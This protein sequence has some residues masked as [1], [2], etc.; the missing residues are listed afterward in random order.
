[1]NSKT[2][3][4]L[5]FLLT[6]V[7]IASMVTNS[8]AQ[9]AQPA[10]IQ[11]AEGLVNA[12]FGAQQAGTRYSCVLT[13]G[14]NGFMLVC[15]P[16]NPT[17]TPVVQPTQTQSPPTVIPSVT[18]TA[19]SHETNT[20]MPTQPSPT[21]NSGGSILPFAGSPLCPDTNGDGHSDVTDNVKYGTA[22]DSALWH[23]L[24]NEVDGCHYDHEHGD[25]P[26]L[27]D[28]IFGALG[29]QWGGSGIDHPFHT[30]DE[31]NNF[32]HRAHK[33][34]VFLNNACV[35]INGAQNCI[36]NFRILHHLDFHAMGTRF[37]SFWIEM[38]ICKPSN[39][40]DCGIVRRGGHLDFGP[41]VNQSQPGNVNGE[42]QVPIPADL[43]PFPLVTCGTS[44]R[45]A[46]NPPNINNSRFATWYGNQYPSFGCLPSQF[47]ADGIALG[48]I[49]IGVLTADVWAPLDLANPTEPNVTCPDGSCGQ[50]N[51][52]REQ[53][54]LV[55]GE[56]NAQLDARDGVTDGYITLKGFANIY[57]FID[58]SCTAVSV[59]CVPFE[60]I[61][62][63]V[64]SYQFRFNTPKEYDIFFN[65]QTSGWIVYPN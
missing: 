11:N 8:T 42:L 43:T 36:K 20:P 25:N 26:A 6:I 18:Q 9:I 5:L 49:Q 1:M 56:F 10:I 52:R 57:G 30:P 60:F 65:G 55:A 58:S 24:W 46:H 21:P 54:H 33:V 45:R 22:P 50:N 28:A 48:V 53:G 47:D 16:F 32:K 62:V 44:N 2:T 15:N 40:T 19:H 23:D 29:S 12:S 27:A 34:T 59:N 13:Q 41:L 64:G 37:H 14:S 35:S 39:P 63:P 61:H 17:R 7:V 31:H 38:E 3:N 51:S 4:V